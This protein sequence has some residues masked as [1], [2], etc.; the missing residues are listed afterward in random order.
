MVS[1]IAR[2][3]FLPVVLLLGTTTAWAAR[4]DIDPNYGVGGALQVSPSV[5]LALPGDRLLIANGG[6]P[7]GLIVRVVDATGRNVPSFGDGGV[8]TIGGTAATSFLPGAVALAPNGDLIF[9]GTRADTQGMGLLRLDMNG[10][11][12]ASFGS[13]GDGFVDTSVA[14]ARVLA[15]AVTP[16]GRILLANGTVDDFC[17]SPVRLQQLLANGQPDTGF[18]GDGFVEIPEIPIV[19]LC[20]SAVVFGERAS[21]GFI[22]GDGRNIVAVDAAGSIDPTFGVNGRLVATELARAR[23]LVLPDGGLLI[24]ASNNVVPSPNETVFLKFDQNGQPDLSFGAGTGSTNVNLG[25]VLLGTSSYGGFVDQPALDPDGRHVVAHLSVLNA[26]GSLI[27][28]GIAR[29]TMDGTP[30]TG[31]GRNGLACLNFDL[32]LDVVQ[33]SGAPLFFE[34]YNSAI[35]RLLPDSKPSPGLLRVVTTSV[36]V[37][38]SDGTAAVVIER[39]A[40]RD[41]AISANYATG[42]RQGWINRIYCSNGRCPT[43]LASVGSDYMAASGRLDWASGEDGQR[44][45]NLAIFDDP[46]DESAFP[47]S[48]G[49]DF[50]DPGGGAL[51][52]AASPTIY[53]LDNDP[54][55]P[56]PPPPPPPPSSGGGGSFSW[57][58]LLALSA[59]LLLRRRR[60]QHGRSGPAELLQ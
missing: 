9:A 14:T 35:H 60:H 24:L 37:G 30:D 36:T 59:Q 7:D 55:G 13:R 26:D 12:V 53:I 42:T 54:P 1:R 15:M 51:L 19:D 22:V 41:G 50:S 16:D 27:C 23:G 4:G 57:A 34:G 20:T 28:S 8:A 49:V 6:T 31:F 56:P 3:A 39:V 48:F 40:G 18:G 43:P 32:I 10:H 38:E 11:P 33:S 25:A 52:L 29:L 44:T 17:A 21:G 58:A 46:S 47:E 5:L 2:I 45:V